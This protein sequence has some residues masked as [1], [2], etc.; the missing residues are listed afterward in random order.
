MQF[1]ITPTQLPPASTQATGE[2][3]HQLEEFSYAL[4][5][6][7]FRWITGAIMV[8]PGSRKPQSGSLGSRRAAARGFDSED[9]LVQLCGFS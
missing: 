8:H 3:A 6:L 7:W 2:P 4:S 1:S 9:I 5:I